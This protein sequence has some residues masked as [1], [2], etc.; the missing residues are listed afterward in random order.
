MIRATW[1]AEA[2]RLYDTGKFTYADLGKRFGVSRFGVY[3]ALNKS[4]TAL[5]VAPKPVKWTKEYRAQ[6]IRE[7]MRK[8][9]RAGL[10]K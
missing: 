3:R 8:R 10:C 4:L 2:I 7:Y 6:Y 1:H 9:R 5:G